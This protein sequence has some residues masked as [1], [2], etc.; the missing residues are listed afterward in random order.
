MAYFYIKHESNVKILI[1]QPSDTIDY[2]LF[3]WTFLIMYYLFLVDIF[4]T[5]KVFIIKFVK[6]ETVFKKRNHMFLFRIPLSI[7]SEKVVWLL[8]SSQRK[9]LSFTCSS[10]GTQTS[11]ILDKILNVDMLTNH[12]QREKELN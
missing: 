6:R 11:V 2:W 9:S 7:F 4:K 1:Y 5:L 8:T 10:C 3:V 12:Q